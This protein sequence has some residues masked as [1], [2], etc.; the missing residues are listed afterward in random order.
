MP[1]CPAAPSLE[2][3]LLTIDA[4]CHIFNGSDLQVKDFFKYVAWNEKGVL[5]P[6]SAAVGAVLEDLVWEGG[7]NGDDE[8]HM[9]RKFETC[10]SELTRRS[11]IKR[12]HDKGY[13][14]ARKALLRTKALSSPAQRRRQRLS[15][16]LSPTNAAG[17]ENVLAE[18]Y[19]RLQPKSR[20]AYIELRDN[21]YSAIR[22]TTSWHGWR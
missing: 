10:I 20:D 13:L 22:T 16:P 4:H 2:P 7:P 11:L 3:P 17:S 5:A 19:E 15:G 8:L 6:V 21:T 9:L 18:M 1:P 14:V 12:H